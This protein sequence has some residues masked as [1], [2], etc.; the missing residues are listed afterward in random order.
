MDYYMKRLMIF[1]II[2][3]TLYSIATTASQ[4]NKLNDCMMLAEQVYRTIDS[5][6]VSNKDQEAYTAFIRLNRYSYDMY[7]SIKK[8][9]NISRVIVYKNSKISHFFRL[10]KL[11]NC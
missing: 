3:I 4:S 1:L 5:T 11:R 2:Q 9:Y 8:K 6:T 10:I 7:M